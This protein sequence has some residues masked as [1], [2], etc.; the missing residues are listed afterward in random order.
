MDTLT[1]ATRWQVSSEDEEDYMADDLFLVRDHLGSVV[2]TL[3]AQKTCTMWMEPPGPGEGDPECGLSAYVLNP[4]ETFEYDPYGQPTAHVPASESTPQGPG[5]LALK[6]TGAFAMSGENSG[7][8]LLDRNDISRPNGTPGNTWVR[9]GAVPAAQSHHGWNYLFTARPWDSDVRQY[10]I[11]NRWYDPLQGRWTAVDPIGY[12]GGLNQ[13][14]YCGG[15]PVSRL[16]RIGLAYLLVNIRPTTHSDCWS[17]GT[18]P[19][20]GIEL[21]TDKLEQIGAWGYHINGWIDE[22]TGKGV[23]SYHYNDHFAIYIPD[24]QVQDLFN[25]FNGRVG[26]WVGTGDEPINGIPPY[27]LEDRNCTTIMCEDLN[28]I[29]GP[30]SSGSLFEPRKPT[31]EELSYIGK[32]VQKPESFKDADIPDSLSLPLRQDIRFVHFTPDELKHAEWMFAE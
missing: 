3:K 27:D 1:G 31:C 19:H 15:N 26:T 12:R 22:A 6:T 24:D 11:R 25:E 13:Y 7:Y 17:E 4:I 8:T 2:M 28:R 30:D 9:N 23:E 10:Y 21:R 20:I 16:D 14:A 5:Y 32:F 29:V 18:V